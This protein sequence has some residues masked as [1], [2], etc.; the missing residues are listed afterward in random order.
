MSK[1][2]YVSASQFSGTTLLSFLLNQ[3]SAIAT[4]GHT[5]GWSFDD[6]DDFRCSCG[7]R[8]ADCPLF[9][10]VAMAYQRN[11]L[12]FRADDFGT[13][14]RV[15]ENGAVNYYLTEALPKFGV[16]WLELGR[17]RVVSFIPHYRRLL[18]QQL[19]SNKVFMDAVLDYW[20][21]DCFLDNS[22]S[23]FRLRRLAKSGIFD[24]H[25]LHLVRD[26]RGVA[27]S[28]MKNSGFTAEA[29]A[30]S[31]IKRHRDILRICSSIPK[32]IRIYYEELCESPDSI[33][34]RIYQFVGV[35]QQSFTGNFKNTEHHILGNRMRLSDGAIRLDEKWKRNLD[36]ESR[37]RIE[38]ELRR[39]L[40][41]HRDSE[42]GS[43][44]EHY[45][46]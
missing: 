21:A 35:S 40:L 30:R 16:T 28:L 20:G 37:G 43:I 39:F 9:C 4:I 12:A 38:Q 44:I 11:G 31:W 17:D 14:F 19:Q 13:A 2:L 33:L 18:Q 8:I 3:H 32:S 45:L 22:H 36:P 25:N 27:L 5:M 26:P 6:P 29:A 41:R 34:N 15:S 42:L 1:L 46:G 24:V 7:K 10:H 23:P